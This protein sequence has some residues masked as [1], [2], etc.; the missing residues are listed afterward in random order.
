VA[1]PGHPE[2][3]LLENHVRIVALTPDLQRVSF[4]NVTGFL[5][6]STTTELLLSLILIKGLIRALR[7]LLPMQVSSSAL[8]LLWRENLGKVA[9]GSV[10]RAGATNDFGLGQSDP[11]PALRKYS[12]LRR[13]FTYVII[14]KLVAVRLWL[15]VV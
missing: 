9:T 1:T 2:P 11:A 5:Y 13:N 6:H 12:V 3:L 15:C 14:A 8:W 7:T 10:P 4:Y